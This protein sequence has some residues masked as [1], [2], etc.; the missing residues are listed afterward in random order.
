M[1][2]INVELDSALKKSIPLPNMLPKRKY[3]P[4]TD[5][6]FGNMINYLELPNFIEDQYEKEFFSNTHL[7][8]TTSNRKISKLNTIQNINQNQNQEKEIYENYSE[9]E[10]YLNSII[11]KVVYS[12]YIILGKQ[13]QLSNIYNLNNS[14][15]L[16]VKGIK[17]NEDQ[18]PNYVFGISKIKESL[19]F[20]SRF[21][22]GNLLY[23]FQLS[24]HSYQLILHNDSNTY[25]Y[26]QWFF[27]KVSSFSKLNSVQFNILNLSQ[28]GSLFS[29]GMK[30]SVYSMTKASKD[31]VGWHRSGFN[32][33]FYQNGLYKMTNNRR[34]N[35]SSLQFSYS[36]EYDNDEV[37]FALNIPFTY[38]KLCG[39]LRNFEINDKKY[40]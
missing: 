12:K 3:Y 21:E 38:S 31:K 6:Y 33:N 1:E 11:D 15:Y 14:E 2:E 28:K 39:I 4:E 34:K 29:K 30:V 40:K 13:V 36:F 32:I 24:E 18:L 10:F 5:V 27:F 17:T 16:Y 9:I 35:Y 19:K 22:S 7:S 25:G 20:E 23:A 26:N 8:N 37:Y